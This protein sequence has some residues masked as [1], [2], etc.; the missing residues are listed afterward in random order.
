MPGEQEFYKTE[1]QVFDIPSKSDI[2][3]KLDT[4]KQQS[5]QVYR[6]PRKKSK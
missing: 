2:N 6:A 3:V 5:I 1:L 4:V